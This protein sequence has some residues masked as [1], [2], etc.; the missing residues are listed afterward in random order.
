MIRISAAVL[1]LALAACDA[2]PFAATAPMDI[3][4]RWKSTARA[5]ESKGGF[6]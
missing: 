3:A 4:R 2:S 1:A 6:D 5:R